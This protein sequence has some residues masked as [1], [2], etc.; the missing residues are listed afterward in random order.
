MKS[1]LSRNFKVK[2]E[3]SVKKAASLVALSLIYAIVLS[4]IFLLTYSSISAIQRRSNPDLELQE[5]H[6]YLTDSAT[7]VPKIPEVAAALTS[8]VITRQVM[9][10]VKLWTSIYDFNNKYLFK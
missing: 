6:Q 8:L 4:S 3:K 10:A 2:L 9:K 7:R 1:N 5:L